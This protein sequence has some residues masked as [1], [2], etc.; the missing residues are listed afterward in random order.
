MAHWTGHKSICAA[1]RAH[2]NGPEISGSRASWKLKENQNYLFN[3]NGSQYAG[4]IENGVPHGRGTVKSPLIGVY[5]GDF[6]A[7]ELHGQGIMKYHE[8]GSV[9]E[10]DWK[11]GKCHGL[12]ITKFPD[13]RF[14]EGDYRHGAPNGRCIMKDFDG[15]FYE[16][17][18]ENGKPMAKVSSSTPTAASTRAV[19]R[20]ENHMEEVL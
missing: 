12:G 14:I 17:D 11:D 8:D 2:P 4:D 13:D 19:S 16:G 7:G 1:I 15:Y 6:K 9:Y 3:F 18:Y 10:G 5:K 20:M